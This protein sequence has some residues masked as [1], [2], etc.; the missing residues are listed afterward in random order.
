MNHQED[1]S[2]ELDDS[3]D[4]DGDLS[5]L[6]PKTKEGGGPATYEKLRQM[7]RRFHKQEPPNPFYREKIPYKTIVIVRSPPIKLGRL[8]C[9]SWAA[10]FS[11]C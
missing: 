11:C 6:R 7:S 2:T 1:R 5:D 8:S 10:S 4:S 9:F 3:I